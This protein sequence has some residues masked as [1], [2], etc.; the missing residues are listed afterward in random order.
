MGLLAYDIG[1]GYLLLISWKCTQLVLLGKH[2]FSHTVFA[3]W[4]IY[5]CQE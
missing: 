2:S 4:H 1:K 5:L 3:P